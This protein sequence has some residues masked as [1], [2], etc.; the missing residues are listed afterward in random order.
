MTQYTTHASSSHGSDSSNITQYMPNTGMY[1]GQVPWPQP[2]Y[3]HPGYAPARPHFPHG[4]VSHNG[5][6]GTAPPHAPVAPST[7]MY[8]GQVPWPQPAYIHP[9][10]APARPHCP[11]GGVSRNG[12]NGTAPPHAPVAPSSGVGPGVPPHAFQAGQNSPYPPLTAAAP[13]QQHPSVFPITGSASTSLSVRKKRAGEE[14]VADDRNVKR[15]KVDAKNPDSET[16]LE[17]EDPVLVEPVLPS[18]VREITL[19]EAGGDL[20]FWRWINDKEDLADP[21]PPLSDSPLPPSQETLPT[22]PAKNTQ[23]L[24]ETEGLV[25]VEP[26]LPPSQVQEITLPNVGGDPDVRRWINEIK[27]LA[28]TIPVPP[29]SNDLDFWRWVN[30][31]EHPA[32]PAPALSDSP[33]SPAPEIPT[34]EE[35]LYSWMLKHDFVHQE[36]VE[37]P[38]YWLFRPGREHPAFL[39]NVDPDAFERI[40]EPPASLFPS[41][42]T[43]MDQD[44]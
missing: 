33:V 12:T 17:I 42:P 5:T 16:A 13:P 34:T 26:V 1:M 32:Y 30:D 3:I 43:P 6:N 10:Y 9:G 15:R 41:P 27:D 29:F 7:G 39:Y 22:E 21:A 19:A 25:L 4:G 8:M 38:D 18:Q 35:D 31:T 2:A 11:H 37:D 23:D 40:T 24:L 14:R 20:G 44:M 28:D 36:A